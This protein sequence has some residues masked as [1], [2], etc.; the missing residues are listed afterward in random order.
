M[1]AP[2]LRARLDADLLDERAAGLTVGLERVGLAAASGTARASAGRA[3]ARAAAPRRPAPRARRRPRGGGPP[4]GRASIAS[5][6]AA[7]RSSSSRRISAAANGSSAT[8][9]SGGPRHSASASRGAP[10]RQSRSK[11]ADVDVVGREPQLVAVP[12]RDDRRAVAARRQRLAQ[13]RDVE[14]DQLAAV[15]GGRSPHSPSIRRSVETVARRGAPASRAARAACR[16]RGRPARPSTLAST[17]PRTLIC[18]CGLL[19]TLNADRTPGG[20]CPGF[21][22][23]ELPARFPGATSGHQPTGY[24]KEVAMKFSSHTRRL[25]TA[26]LTLVVAPRWQRPSGPRPSL[27][28][29]QPSS[30]KIGDTPADFSASRPPRSRGAT[31]WSTTR[32]RAARSSTSS[33]PRSRSSGPSARSCATSTRRCCSASSS[34]ALLIVLRRRVRAH[35]RLPAQPRRA[36]PRTHRRNTERPARDAGLSVRR[37]G[38]RRPLRSAR[39]GSAGIATRAVDRAGVPGRCR[40]SRGRTASATPGSA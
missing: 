14:L 12:A 16:R 37:A 26:A 27:D 31:R 18:T 40:R 34:T 29:P 24:P 1:Q 30:V 8:S 5:S 19:R 3:A 35:R 2:Q 33:R 39:R 28:Y 36:Q 10:P 38:L 9:S 6:S 7:S 20:K 11:R 4:R 22:V 13:L 32:A 25:G 23:L 17:G 15:A 21:T